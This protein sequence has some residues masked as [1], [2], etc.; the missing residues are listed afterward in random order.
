MIA[1]AIKKKKRSCE[2]NYDTVLL[3]RIFLI[4]MVLNLDIVFSVM[5]IFRKGKYKQ[6][7]LIK[8]FY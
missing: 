8:Y 2:L 4:L 5:Y 1:C 7:K 6:N 3:H